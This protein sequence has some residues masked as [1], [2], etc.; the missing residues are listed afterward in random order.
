MRILLTRRE[1]L[2]VPDGINMSIFALAQEYL[3][4]GH[5]VHVLGGDGD[6][7]GELADVYAVA[8]L[9]AVETVNLPRDVR[10]NGMSLGWLL[11]GRQRISGLSP[12]VVIC[13]DGPFPFR[14]A[15]PNCSIAINVDAG[16]GRLRRLRDAYKRFAYDR[17]GPIVTASSE[18][19][20]ALARQLGVPPDGIVVIPPC[21]DLPAYES[22]PWQERDDL[23]LHLGTTPY[24]NAPAALAAFALLPDEGVR[25]LVTGPVDD[26]LTRLHSALPAD[27]RRRVDLLGEVPVAR[28]LVLLRQAKVVSFPRRYTTPTVS[29]AMIEPLAT[30]TPV[31]GSTEVSADVLT[32]GVNGLVCEPEDPESIA[33]AYEAS[34]DATTW[35]RLSDGA[36]RSAR[37]YA[38]PPTATAFLDLLGI[39]S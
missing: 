12:D 21:V 17:S 5:Q 19:R 38:A 34:L 22:A 31:V 8:E 36:L 39:G 7:A 33:A 16:G 18:G 10:Y 24:E 30:G 26:E 23:I 6:D 25:M 1:A 11:R 9:P 20:A 28:R 37:R 27:A 13:H 29:S 2:D 4:K 3:R 14:I 35:Q 15:T 32:H